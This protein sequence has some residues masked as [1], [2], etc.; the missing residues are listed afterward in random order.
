MSH[1]IWIYTVANSI[2]FI[3]GVLCEKIS[4]LVQNHFGQLHLSFMGDYFE[5]D[6]KKEMIVVFKYFG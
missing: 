1:L 4:N 6:G 5:N 2:N 3:F